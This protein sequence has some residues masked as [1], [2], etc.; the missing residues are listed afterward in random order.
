MILLFFYLG[1]E[2]VFSKTGCDAAAITDMLGGHAG[3]TNSTILQYLGIVEQRTNELLQ[4]Q[5]F[6]Q[7]KVKYTI[8]GTMQ[9]SCEFLC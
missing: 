2:S 1:I 6:I 8:T 4:L 3:V 9:K 7:A 5:A